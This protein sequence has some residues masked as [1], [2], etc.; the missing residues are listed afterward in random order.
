MPKYTT[1]L[2]LLVP[3][4]TNGTKWYNALLYQQRQRDEQV[5]STN[6]FSPD[7]GGLSFSLESFT[8]TSAEGALQKAFYFSKQPM[9]LAP[10]S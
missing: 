5:Y 7:D 1:V 9:K 10:Q 8:F 6:S 3:T 4:N 2:Q